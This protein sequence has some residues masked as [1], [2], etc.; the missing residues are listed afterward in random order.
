MRGKPFEIADISD[1]CMKLKCN[2]VEIWTVIEVETEGFGFNADRSIKCLFERH[3]FHRLT[4]GKFDAAIPSLSNSRPGGYG[5]KSSQL[6]RFNEA[7]KYDRHA[8]LRAT[9][10]GLGQ[11]MGFNHF[12]AGYDDP[13]KM[14]AKFRESERF[15]LMALVK[16]IEAFGVAEA[17]K[18]HDWRRFAR[19]YNGP[20]AEKNGYD[21]KLRAA[22]EK[23]SR[24][25]ALPS[26][27]VRAR[28]A[29]LLYQGLYAG[30]VDG[31]EGPLTLA[32]EREAQSVQGT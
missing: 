10:W 1:A 2:P 22:Y 12:H 30:E 3:V 20:D 4:N 7:A 6:D 17:L 21:K 8:A 11:I 24:P 23:L 25:G 16:V 14:V 19:W 13:E 29:E 9:S 28:Q 31:I 27:T 5:Y 15:Q 18:F 26:V 32:A